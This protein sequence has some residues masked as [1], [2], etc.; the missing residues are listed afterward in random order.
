MARIASPVGD[1]ATRAYVLAGAEDFR[2]LMCAT[3]LDDGAESAQYASDALSPKVDALRSGKA[4]QVHRFELPD[5]H[6]LRGR[7]H[8]SDYVLLDVDNT[9][10]EI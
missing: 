2:R 10:S 5:D 6:P 8:P 4:V 3:L 7:W 9:V 1:A